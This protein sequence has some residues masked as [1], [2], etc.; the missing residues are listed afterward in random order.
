VL[1]AVTGFGSVWRQRFGTEDGRGRFSMPVYYNTT[2]VVVNGHLR[3][4][5]QICGYAR[6]Q[7]A[8]G[9]DPNHLSRMINR[10][11]DCETPS[12]W[13]GCNKVLFKRILSANEKPDW[14]LVLARSALHGKL[15]IGMEGWRSGD[16]W[17]LS[18]SEG[19]GQQEAMLLLPPGGWLRT[20]LGKFVLKAPE[21]AVSG[22]PLVLVNEN[23]VDSRHAL[24]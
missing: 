12:V 17:L 10:V 23:S 20:H 11:F 16:S 24:S 2:G 5:P 9:F 1:V 3:Q 14:Y 15:P 18:F 22:V 7:A 13:L 8:G 19:A 4:R 21:Q 6:F